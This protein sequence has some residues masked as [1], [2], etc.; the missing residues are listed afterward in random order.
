[1]SNS[2]NSPNGSGNTDTNP[3][4]N[5]GTN[6]T[7][8]ANTNPT[9][10]ANT[11]NANTPNTLSTEDFEKDLELELELKLKE[12]RTRRTQQYNDKKFGAWI[13]AMR[14]RT[15]PLSL[16][17]LA[18]GASCAALDSKFSLSIFIMSLV[19]G[20]CLQILSNFANDYG[21]AQKGTD[22]E[23]RVGPLRTVSAGL[24]SQKEMLGAIKLT[25]A[26]TIIST[27]LLLFISFGTNAVA[28][29]IFGF[30][31]AASI[32]A[33]LAYTMGKN[34]YGYSGKGDIFVFI[35]FGLVAVLG[36]YSLYG[37]NFYNAPI[38][39]AI[40]AGLFSTAVLNVNNIR[41][42]KSDAYHGKHTF[43]LSLGETPAR[44]YHLVLVSM[45][46]L[47][48]IVYLLLMHG[49]SSLIL[50][51]FAAPVIHSAYTVYHS[52]NSK[53]LDTQLKITALGTGIF[54][55]ILSIILPIW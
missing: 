13:H 46:I 10:N 33:A 22:G 6:P 38:F 37:A 23:D 40:A 27:M 26:C 2:I 7:G 11:G 39:P 4:G 19:T 29:L 15:L 25:I 21:D 8:N 48:W 41:D 16:S 32:V 31:A 3:T 1:M 18:L 49:F 20:L 28:W 5:A 34:P 9:G 42:M 17:G 50:L 53:V 45:G 14:L 35:F 36:S 24:I 30:L 12:D 54:H 52:Y 55:I 43:A 51:V 44:Q 47:F